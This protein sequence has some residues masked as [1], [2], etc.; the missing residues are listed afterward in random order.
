MGMEKLERSDKVNRGKTPRVQVFGK[1]RVQ[2]KMESERITL[3]SSLGGTGV[4]ASEQPHLSYR[5]IRRTTVGGCR[6]ANGSLE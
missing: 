5:E 4:E 3:E 2:G 1:E 6:H